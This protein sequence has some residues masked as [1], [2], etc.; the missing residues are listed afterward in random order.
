MTGESQRD[1]NDDFLD[2]DFV[3]ED[4]A[5]KNDDLDRL[6]ETPPEHGKAAAAGEPD[7]EDVLFAEPKVDEPSATFQGGPQFAE[8]SGGAWDGDALDLDAEAAGH[9]AATPADA[10]AAAEQTFTKELDSLL[11]SDEDFALDSEQELEVIGGG[12]ASEGDGISEFEQSGPFVLDDGEGLWQDE[13]QSDAEESD[14][15]L[16]AAT[17]DAELETHEPGW[18]PL[19]SA[20]VDDLAEVGEVSRAEEEADADAD[21]VYGES[22]E[23]SEAHELVGVAA[24]AEG[25]DIYVQEEEDHE[26]IG[27][28]SHGG[29]GFRVLLS[30]AAALMVL[31]GGALVVLR[32]E[33]VGLRLQPERIE[34]AQVTRPAVTVDVPTP[35][36]PTPVAA[37]TEPP[38]VPI[39]PAPVEPAPI[40]PAPV[41]PPEP[42][43]VV[44]EPP[45]VEPVPPV[46]VEP[47]PVVEPPVAEPVAVEPARANEP[48][49]PVVQAP[50][51]E[52]P[53]W[54]VAVTGPQPGADGRPQQHH[55]VRVDDELMIGEPEP[56]AD[57]TAS[58][59]SVL[60]GSRAFA[61]LQNG[62]FFIG[63]VKAA[64]TQRITLRVDNGE[65]TIPTAAI[66]RLTELGSADYED[67][68]KVTSGFVRL[69]NNN[70]LVGGI[71]SGIADD[72]VVLEF[73]KNRVMLPK[74]LVGQVVQGDGDAAIRLDTTREEDDWL[75][76]LV[77]RQL[78]TG[79][80][81]EPPP[82]PQ[83]TQPPR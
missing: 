2:D 43:V 69:T 40:E 47:A 34:Q 30:I 79:T 7:A 76:R 75:R 59:A 11:Q 61:Q 45:P 37:V 67:L 60:P 77:E 23:P 35:T 63:N 13:A 15:P 62:N 58:P 72:H 6:F 10:M 64:D 1:D 31:A 73:R 44:T 8:Q 82:A 22:F 51:P 5:P 19:P 17:D 56:V 4:I 54:P 21:P 18:E 3:I 20:N 83:G 66:A 16:Q 71:L 12:A 36:A 29:R 65:V 39:E 28:A 50:T 49:L 55:L 38:P 68:Q 25:H 48:T 81:A 53:G 27:A 32:P 42:T 74:A 46:A 52:L 14:L 80:G 57:R 26:V 33:W 24:E 9:T 70:R 41:Q 78:G